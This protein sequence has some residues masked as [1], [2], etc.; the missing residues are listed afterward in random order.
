LVTA[1]ATLAWV[2]GAAHAQVIRGTIVDSETREPV[3]LAYVGLLAPGRELVVAGLAEFDGT[4]SLEAPQEGSYFLYVDRTGY[5][6]ILDG[7]FELGA[8]GELEL[9]IGMRPEPV[10]LTPLVVGVEGGVADLSA[11]GFYERRD[12]GFGHFI[13][14]ETIERVA[15]DNLTDALRNIPRL[16]V[17]TPA[18]S[19]VAPTQVLS[20][21]IFVRYG[22]EY[23]S[24]T[25]YIDGRPVVFGTTQAT[26]RAVRPD[27]FVDPSEVEAV[28]VYTSPADTPLVY[29]NTGGCGVVVIWTR[30]R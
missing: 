11:V 13:E 26:R 19:A 15:V 9:S 5:R 7:L 18:P 22:T 24:P 4:F 23:C 8:G 16:Q 21:Q 27:D 14:R 28:E 29:E 10:E 17:T 20:P 2:S 1:C 30:K 25:L 6:P 12:R 3:V